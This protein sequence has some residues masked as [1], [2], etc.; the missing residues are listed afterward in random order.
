MLDTL[1][2]LPTPSSLWLLVRCA[3]AHTTYLLIPSS[4]SNCYWN[5]QLDCPI[6]FLSNSNKIALYFLQGLL[7]NF[8]LMRLRIQKGKFWSPPKKK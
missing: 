7:L 4:P 8:L 3:D 2:S 6:I 1:G 5:V